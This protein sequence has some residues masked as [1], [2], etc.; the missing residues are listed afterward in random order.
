MGNAFTDDLIESIAPKIYRHLM[1][2]G[3]NPE[4]AKDIVQDALYKAV[5]YIDSIDPNRVSAWLFKV[6]VNGYYDLCR[7]H[8]R[9]VEVSIDD[10]VLRD[11]ETPETVLVNSATKFEITEILDGL[12][13]IQKHLL[14]LKYEQNLSYQEI[15]TLL[16][17]P[18]QTIATYLHRAR[19]KFKQAFME[20]E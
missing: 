20:V 10:I 2:I 18:V 9:R 19:Q 3:A 5:L 17:V 16:G 11:E 14:I 13:T 12:G 1:K 8:N 6:A 15:S 7:K 4:D